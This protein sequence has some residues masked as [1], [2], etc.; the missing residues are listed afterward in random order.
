MIFA[1]AFYW[2]ALVNEGDEAHDRAVAAAA[3]HFG[4][5]ITTEWALAEVC[6]AFAS[7]R[8]RRLVDRLRSIWRLDETLILVAADHDWFARGLDLFCSRP[9]K[10]WS[11]TDCISFLVMQDH[12]VTDALTGDRHSTQAGFN[13]LL[14]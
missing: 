9:D 11:L 12:G 1:D 13:A 10:D 7:Q 3:S 5:T 6:D 8:N 2:I 14:A 4:R